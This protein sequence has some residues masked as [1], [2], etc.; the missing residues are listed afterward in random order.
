MGVGD[1]VVVRVE[2]FVKAGVRVEEQMHSVEAAFSGRAMECQLEC[3]HPAAGHSSE[4]T[5]SGILRAHSH[6]AT[7]IHPNHTA[8]CTITLAPQTWPTLRQSVT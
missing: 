5:D 4:N 3:E 6:E 1:S 2:K 7:G 8:K